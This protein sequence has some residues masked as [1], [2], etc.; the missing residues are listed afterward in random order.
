VENLP[1]VNSGSIVLPEN[2]ERFDSK[3]GCFG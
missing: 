2:I 1:Q 3:S